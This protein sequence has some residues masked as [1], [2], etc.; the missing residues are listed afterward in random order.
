MQDWIN[1]NFPIFFP[2]FFVGMWI[3][4]GYWIALIGGWRLLAQRFRFQGAFL[5][6]KWHMQSAR[7]RWLG[8]Y[9][10]V[11]TLG[12]DSTGLFIVPLFLF[13]AWHPPLFIPWAEITAQPKTLFFFFKYVELR[14]GRAEEIPFMI[15]AS[16]AA[17]IETAAG[18]G[19]PTGY[20]R[21]LEVPPPPIG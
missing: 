14:L 5:G 16:L 1:Q 4:V 12:A 8:N 13:R 7:M 20:E 19:W 10:N 2:F 6:E 3:L 15:R 18:P 11:L 9:N 21:A 17:K